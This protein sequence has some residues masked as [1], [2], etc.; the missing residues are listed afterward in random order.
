MPRKIVLRRRVHLLLLIA[1]ALPSLCFGDI[2]ITFLDSGLPVQLLFN[3]IG[4]LG[5]SPSG[6]PEVCSL[7]STGSFAPNLDLPYNIFEPGGLGLSDTLEITTDSTGG[8]ITSTF[9]ST[10]GGPLVPLSNATSLIEDGTV[11]TAASIQNGDSFY[12][13]LFKSTINVST[14]PEPRW[15]G[16]LILGMLGLAARAREWAR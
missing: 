16:L 12:N 2:N 1:L 5:C 3:G 14:V 15:I 10:A 7:S 8:S 6:H 4:P 11:Q 9:V 13:V